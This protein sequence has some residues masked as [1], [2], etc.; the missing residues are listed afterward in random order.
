[1]H[2][3]T[4][5]IFNFPESR[6]AGLGAV[7]TDGGAFPDTL[8]LAALPR[9]TPAAAA[10]YSVHG[11]CHPEFVGASSR[12]THSMSV[13]R[14]SFAVPVALAISLAVAISPLPANPRC[15]RCGPHTLAFLR[16][17]RKSA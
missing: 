4:S 10:A 17:T 1:M 7:L 16:L 11:Q 14:D 9:S 2:S 12:R 8:L 3:T 6:G 13:D 5:A 15:V